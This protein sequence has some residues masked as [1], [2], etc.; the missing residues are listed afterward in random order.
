MSEIECVKEFWNEASCGEDLYLAEQTKEGYLAQSRERYRLEPYILDFA[1]F[2]GYEGKKVL[3]IGLGL[4]A[5]H[6]NFAEAGAKL[7]GIDL[8]ERSVK[9]TQKRMELMGLNSTVEQ[10]NAEALNIKDESF[11]L[12]YSWGV[13]HHSPNTPQCIKE[14]YRVLKAGGKTKIMIYYKYS[15][16]GLMLW[17]RYGLLKG[18]PLTTLE[19]IYADYLESPGTKAYSKTEAKAIF[20][21]AGFKDI[22]IETVLTHADLLESAA[23]QR[24]RGGLLSFAKKVWP[25]GLIKAVFPNFGLFMMVDAQK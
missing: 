12:V 25:R 6:Q 4:G 20:T 3:E 7:T 5:D 19:K 11:D 13:L 24:H 2:R 18:K 15:F 16:V 23:G 9:H 8:T 14:V 21:N 1:N 22:K 10:G 17:A